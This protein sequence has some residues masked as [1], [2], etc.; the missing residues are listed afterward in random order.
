M[1]AN[2]PGYWRQKADE[3]Q[4]RAS[5]LHDPHAKKI[6]L[7]IAMMYDA[8]AL[9]VELREAKAQATSPN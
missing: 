6:L 7:Q 2:D 5:R 8:M 1:R 9:R 3:A 4:D